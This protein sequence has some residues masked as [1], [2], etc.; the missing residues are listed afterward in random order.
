M[1][2]VPGFENDLFIS[3]AHADDVAWI[4]AFEKSLREEL[5]RKLGSEVTVWQDAR[6]L[7]LGQNWEAEISEGIRRSATFIPIISPSYKNSDWCTRERLTFMNLF[8]TIEALEGSNRFLKIIKKSWDNDDHLE[9]LPKLQHLVFYRREDGPA[10]EIEYLPGSEEF[11]LSIAHAVSA[12]AQ[13]LRTMRRQRERV[14][15]ASPSEDCLDYWEAL[16]GELQCQSYDVQPEGRR[17]RSFTDKYVRREMDGALF[18]V[19]LLGGVYDAFSEHQITLAAELERKL[20]FWF[21][22]GAEETANERQRRLLALIRDGKRSDGAELP[23]GWALLIERS[24]RKL[25]QEILSMLKPQ[26]GA[27]PPLGRANGSPRVYLLCDPTTQEDT[28]FALGLQQE[29]LQKEGMEA[30]L[31]QAGLPTAADFTM[32]HQALLRDCD[33]VLLYSNA[34][35]DQWLLQTVPQVLFAEKLVN[36]PPL[37]SKA[38]LLNDPTP[39]EG[40][41]NIK[42]I[43]R[44]QQFQLGDLEPFLAPLRHDGGA[45]GN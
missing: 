18:S 19:H 40:Y 4:K 32:Q 36:R 9:F 16:R 13:I 31:P 24:P 15:V 29:L 22:T 34:A 10:G 28:A 6:E 43:P 41:P 3:Y 20:V 35:P 14:F 39:W 1:S 37:R 21:A 2:F 38:F 44:R 17:D 23:Q 42:V 45:R 5:A 11:R 30:F 8:P 33:G 26:R 25:I 7:R 27:P 12:I